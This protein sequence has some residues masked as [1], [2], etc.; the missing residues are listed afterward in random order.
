M[1]KKFESTRKR[2]GLFREDN[3]HEEKTVD[4]QRNG[5]QCEQPGGRLSVLTY[6]LEVMVGKVVLMQPRLNSIH[7]AEDNAPPP[8]L[9]PG[10]ASLARRCNYSS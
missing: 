4:T 6:S 3:V 5:G 7:G 2:K 8:L 1:R 9:P 10:Y